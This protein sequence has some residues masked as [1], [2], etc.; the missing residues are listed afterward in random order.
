MPGRQAHV[1]H[2]EH[3][4]GAS[5]GRADSQIAV[6]WTVIGIK[7]DGHRRFALIDDFQ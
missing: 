4:A 1:G 5:N 2:V 7:L 3:A 6:D